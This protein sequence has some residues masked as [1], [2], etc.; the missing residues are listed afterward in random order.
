M[1]DWS[2]LAITLAKGLAGQLPAPLN[3]IGSALLTQAFP[4]S[5]PLD[6][7]QIASLFTSIVREELD[8]SFFDQSAGEIKGIVDYMTTEYPAEKAAGTP[9]GQLWITLDAYDRKCT[10]LIG[11]FSQQRY[12]EGGLNN[13]LVAAGVHFSVLQEKALIDPAHPNDPHASGAAEVIP[14]LVDMYTPMVNGAK[15]ALRTDRLAMIGGIQSDLHTVT[16]RW[17]WK[18]YGTYY[19]DDSYTGARTSEYGEEPTH[20]TTLDQAWSNINADRAQAV[21]D[22]GA[23]FDNDV[24]AKLDVVTAN[25]GLLK[26]DPVPTSP[27]ALQPNWRWCNKCQA[28][29]FAGAAQPGPCPATGSHDR[30]GSANYV[31]A[32]GS[33]PGGG[34]QSNW[35]WCNKCQALAFAG[36]AEPGACSGGGQHAHDGSANYVLAYG[37]DAPGQHSWQ[38]CKNCQVLAF[39]SSAELG[40]CAAGGQHDHNGS[41]DY[42]VRST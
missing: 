33:L 30:T 24:G 35:Q 41:A 10:D 9:H 39:A 7:N 18:R 11:I 5:A 17:S 13:L 21:A 2:D 32:F 23:T 26:L 20:G 1:S 4:A 15:A 19:F 34:V 36:G 3:A 40:P 42:G 31:V 37:A 16:T 6:W 28:L 14:I 12:L 29:T 22:A 27:S 25:W 38:W 8:Q